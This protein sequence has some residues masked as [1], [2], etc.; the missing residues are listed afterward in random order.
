M[1][2]ILVLDAAAQAVFRH[3]GQDR[4][5]IFRHCVLA[6]VGKCPSLGGALEGQQAAW[7]LTL[8]DLTALA[9]MRD[10]PLDVIQYRLAVMNAVDL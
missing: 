5:D 8:R 10:Q 3:G 1:H 9:R 7:R 6:A 4:L 2:A